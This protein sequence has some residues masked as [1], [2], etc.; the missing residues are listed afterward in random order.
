MGMVVGCWVHADAAR[1]ER[2]GLHKRLFFCCALVERTETRRP[3]GL[4]DRR[5]FKSA[6]NR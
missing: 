3:F 5:D 2:V 1:R 4:L 6:R